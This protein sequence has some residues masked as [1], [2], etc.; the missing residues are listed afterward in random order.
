MFQKSVD[1]KYTFS[2]YVILNNETACN[3]IVKEKE[4]QTQSSSLI[5]HSV[6]LHHH[7]TKLAKTKQF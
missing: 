1:K 2:T 4:K 7:C 6:L 5:M 3:V